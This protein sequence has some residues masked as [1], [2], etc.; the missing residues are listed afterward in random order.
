MKNNKHWVS[1]WGNATSIITNKP[2]RYAK[3]ITLRYPIY[4]PFSGK[5]VRLTFDN[6]NGT[7]DVTI[8]SVAGIVI[9]LFPS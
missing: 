6:L 7:E 9:S 3:D 2:E 5:A 4:V 1:I 8:F